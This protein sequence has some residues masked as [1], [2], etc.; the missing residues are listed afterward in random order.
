M[1]LSC[2]VYCDRSVPVASTVRGNST[3]EPGREVS[4][5][6]T[7]MLC[8]TGLEGVFFFL[9]LDGVCPSKGLGSSTWNS[10]PPVCLEKGRGSWRGQAGTLG[11]T[12]SRA[13]SRGQTIRG[14][15][16]TESFSPVLDLPS[17]VWTETGPPCAGHVDTWQVAR[18]LLK[19]R[20]GDEPGNSTIQKE[21]K[22]TRT[23]N[24][25]REKQISGS[26]W[27]Q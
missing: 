8:R 16:R 13:P 17:K 21:A 12:Q 7:G 24:I 23:G 14:Q 26:P 15:T 20:H 6:P 25:P 27:G 3:G 11:G 2:P 10:S 22:E 1:A 4:K 19:N 18:H 9:E 5:H